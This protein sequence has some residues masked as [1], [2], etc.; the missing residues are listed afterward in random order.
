MTIW[1][2]D[3]G[4]LD[5]LSNVVDAASVT[6][7]P[8]NRFKVADAT[9]GDASGTRKALLQAQP[10][11]FAQFSVTMDS[12]AAD[13]LY[14]HLRQPSRSDKNLAEHQ[15]IAWSL[16]ECEDAILVS[17]DKRAAFLAL[18]ELGRSRAAHPSELWLHLLDSGLVTTAQFEDLCERTSRA[19]QCPVPIRCRD[20]AHNP[21]AAEV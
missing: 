13:I 7:W 15:S 6:N 16:A 11:P 1:I 9:A 4:P 8:A 14:N 10:S 18:A 5:T 21:A 12:R 3:D 20:R 2:L 19:E 17:G